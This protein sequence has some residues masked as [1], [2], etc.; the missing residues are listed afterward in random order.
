MHFVGLRIDD[1]QLDIANNLDDATRVVIP[2]GTDGVIVPLNVSSLRAQC[3]EPFIAGLPDRYTKK[4]ILSNIDDAKAVVTVHVQ[5]SDD[6]DVTRH[7]VPL[8]I[9]AAAIR[10]FIEHYLPDRLPEKT[11]C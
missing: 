6:D 3:R 7:T 11:S 8:T 1:V 10:A 5:E 2:S 4:D 9:P